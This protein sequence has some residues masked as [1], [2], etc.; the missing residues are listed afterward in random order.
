MSS[1]QAK[2][3]T[4]ML[5][6]MC[7]PVSGAMIYLMGMEHIYLLQENDTKDNLKKGKNMVMVSIII[8]METVTQGTGLMI[9][10]RGKESMF[11]LRLM[12]N[13]KVNGTMA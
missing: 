10:R 1:D 6:E 2:E 12:K 5:Q 13:M 11:M 7:M 3:F 8:W 9:K 4:I